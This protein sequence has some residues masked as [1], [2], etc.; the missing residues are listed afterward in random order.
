MT[1]ILLRTRKKIPDHIQEI[2]K[3]I[4]D[5]SDKLSIDTFIVGAT[6]RDLI[7]EYVY[8]AKVYRATEDIDFGVAVG[9]WQEYEQLKSSL[10][11]TKEFKIDKRY[12]QR[13]LWES[14]E[15]KMKIDLV[16][17][18]NLEAPD[19][20]I[21]FPPNGDFVMSTVG[22]R[23]AY[24]NSIL[25]EITD[26]LTVRVASLPA[27]AMLKFVAY[28]DRPQERRRDVLDLWFIANNYMDAGNDDRIYDEKASDA[29]LLLEGDFNYRTCGARLLGRDI[30]H[31][32][33]ERT[34]DIISGILSEEA[35]GGGL[36]RAADIIDLL[37]K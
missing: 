9:N 4:S 36:Q 25:L 10:C 34:K 2:L 32:L 1:N 6:A 19:G 18:G 14:H 35:A 30:A 15:H 21:A 3:S 37:Q 24:E 29:D 11:E 26:N 13:I 8:G 12:E 7:F 28:G 23:E 33:N 16:P 20:K 31:L 22:F 17:Y 5:I 27:L